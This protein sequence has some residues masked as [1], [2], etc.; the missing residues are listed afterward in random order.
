MLIFNA[1]S[2]QFDVPFQLGLK[3]QMCWI[4][5]IQMQQIKIA[6]GFKQ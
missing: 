6:S 3:V 5:D 1:N 4:P 2:S